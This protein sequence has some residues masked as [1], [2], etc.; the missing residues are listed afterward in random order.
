LS[1]S[2][3]SYRI[4]RGITPDLFHFENVDSIELNGKLC[5]SLDDAADKLCGVAKGRVKARLGSKGYFTE[6]D[7]IFDLL[8][9]DAASDIER[10]FIES[11]AQNS[12]KSLLHG[13]SIR[14]APITEG[15]F[16]IAALQA[17]VAGLMAKNS[18]AGAALPPQEFPAKMGEA[19]DGLEFVKR[20]FAQAMCSLI[21]FMLNQFAPHPG[22]QYFPFLARLKNVLTKGDFDE[23]IAED[24]VGAYAIPL[25]GVTEVLYSFVSLERVARLSELAK[26]E[27]LLKAGSLSDADKTK[28]RLALLA[29]YSDAPGHIKETKALYKELAHLPSVGRYAKA[30]VY[31]Q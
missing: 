27:S 5:D 28:L 6:Y 3:Q 24:A 13:F 9:N 8:S 12:L 29:C 20:P 22:D 2:T 25:D 18:V 14:V 31:Q 30:M 1:A 11:A 15:Q 10:F 17:Y 16:Y 26:L 7:F 4:V 23:S 19:L 21:R